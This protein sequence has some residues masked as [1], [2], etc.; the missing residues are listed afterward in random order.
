[1]FH[2]SRNTLMANS[3]SL[4]ISI[5]LLTI[6]SASPTPSPSPNTTHFSPPSPPPLQPSSPPSPPPPSPSPPPPSPPLP[7]PS[8]PP[9]S[10]PPPSPPPPPPPSP[11]PPPPSPPPS[12]SPPPPY[13]PPPSPPPP[14]PPSPSPP[15]PSPPPPPQRHPPPLP[16]PSQSPPPPP[17]P[18]SRSH[19]SSSRPRPPPSS[20]SQPQ[21]SQEI[22]NIID[23]LIGASDFTNWAN[24]ISM[25]NPLTLPISA[26]LF[27]PQDQDG[28]LN[29]NTNMDPL[30]LPYH[31]VPQRLSFSDLLLFNTNTRLP[32]LLPDKTILITNTSATNFTLNDSPITRPDVYATNAVT[33]HGIAALLDYSIYGDHDTDGLGFSLPK[34]P[35]QQPQLQ[36]SPADHG[37]TISRAD[38]AR[39]SL[40]SEFS[41]VF[42]LIVCAGLL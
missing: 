4:L 7:S 10:P 31:I 27:I 2:L 33:V 30:L 26:T 29:M 13:P 1:M 3:L 20:P 23:A 15:S 24:I 8:P 37:S 42:L 9:P 35:P 22:N 17:P 16:P 41:I 21:S 18:Q 40:C 28:S 6:T 11:S 32:T 38:A 5:L 12:P 14:P 36:V 39:L 19:P 34:P 25:I